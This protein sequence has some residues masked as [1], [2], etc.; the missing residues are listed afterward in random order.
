[1][2]SLGDSN[3]MLLNIEGLKTYFFVEDGVVKAA[4]GLSLGLRSRETLGIVGE[5]GCGK[6]VMALSILRLIPAPPGRIVAGR[7]LFD[8]YDLLQLSEA[9]M[10]KIRGNKISMIFQEPMTSLDPVFSVGNQ[11]SETLRFHRG[12]SRKE[13]FDLSIEL[14]GMVGIPSP[15]SR[16][17]DY[18]HQMSGG[19]RQRVMIA[20]ALS[21]NP[22][23]MIADEPTTALDVTI[24]AQILDLMQKLKEETKTAIIL[25]SHDLGLV[26][27]YAQYV[28][29]MYAGK[30]VEHTGVG[31]LYNNPLHPYTR[32]LLESIPRIGVRKNR[33]DVIPGWVPDPLNFPSGCRY[34]DRCPDSWEQCNRLDPDLIEVK[35]GHLVRCWKYG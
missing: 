5:S 14:L 30:V 26:A 16:V 24:E 31:E 25:I 2:Q 1:M 32:G 17:R 6:S 28:A 18:P 4:D 15:E 35:K 29:I 7:I 33:L 27:E 20:M 3:E 10:R 9:K 13:A 22:K 23:L 34:G 12:L 19:M 8:G 21:C 11:I